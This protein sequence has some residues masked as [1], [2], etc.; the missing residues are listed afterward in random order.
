[1][2]TLEMFEGRLTVLTGPDAAWARTGASQLRAGLRVR[3]VTVG[4]DIGDPSGDLLGRFGP[5]AAGAVL[6]RPDGYVSWR[7]QSCAADS[8]GDSTARLIT[9]ARA[10]LGLSLAGETL[11]DA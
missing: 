2:S 8:G 9:A 3:T 10:M 4:R 11:M 6:V 5:D 7:T 1:M